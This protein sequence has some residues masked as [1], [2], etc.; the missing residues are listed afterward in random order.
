MV[1]N[2]RV[3]IGNQGL[4]SAMS[5]DDG[6]RVNG[7]LGPPRPADSSSARRL[8]L[9]LIRLSAALRECRALHVQLVV[10][11]RELVA[12]AEHCGVDRTMCL[13]VLEN[14]EI[15]TELIG[16]VRAIHR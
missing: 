13:R 16:M 4:K 10:S 12:P 9:I 8:G 3:E 11:N 6:T 2:I 5:D 14:R 1:K 7:A 15:T